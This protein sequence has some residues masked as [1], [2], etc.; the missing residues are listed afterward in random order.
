MPSMDERRI[1]YKKR[2]IRYSGKYKGRSGNRDKEKECISEGQGVQKKQYRQ[3]EQD[4]QRGQA[5]NPA[6]DASRHHGGQDGFSPDNDRVPEKKGK[7]E[8]NGAPAFVKKTV[9]TVKRTAERA[10]G[11]THAETGN[12]ME[13]DDVFEE[14]K[15]V[16]KTVSVAGGFFV[17]TAAAVKGII[18]LAVSVIKL[19]FSNI[20][21]LGTVLAVTLVGSAI[22][23]ISTLT[24]DFLID[25]EENVASYI[26]MIQYNFT[27]T[28]KEKKA[29]LSCDG[30]TVSGELTDWKEIISFW[31]AFRSRSSKSDRQEYYLTGVDIDDLTK[32][33]YEFN[34]VTY[35]AEPEGEKTMLHVNIENVTLGYMMD[36]YA[37]TTEQRTYVDELLADKEL[38]KKIFSTDELARHAVLETG[39]T[40]EK[41]LEWYGAAENDNWNMAYVMYLIDKCGAGQTVT[42]TLSAEA[43]YN[44][45]QRKGYMSVINIPSEGDIMFLSLSGEMKCG[46][47]TN[48][49][50]V[51]YYVTTG[52]YPGYDM[53]TEIVLDKKSGLII[54]CAR[55][56]VS[57]YSLVQ[58]DIVIAGKFAWPV[59]GYYYVTSAYGARSLLGMSFHYGMDIG[60]PTGTPILACLDGTV[61]YAGYGY[62]LGN[63][64]TID[65]GEG[66]KTVYGHNSSLAVK[67]G[68]IVTQGQVI[69]Y[70]GS[71]GQSTGPHCH[72]GVML[73]GNYNDP[74]QYFGLP[75]GFT[76]DAAP[77]IQ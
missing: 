54:G 48:I 10:G 22:M 51:A 11:K 52:G 3:R 28:M 56:D 61:T 39:Q 64:I 4:G 63:Y 8:E 55:I 66:L 16:K 7:R 25:E 58:P 59:D 36:D 60:C 13:D 26:S 34:S 24:Y 14:T 32:I 76:G 75:V 57:I 18:T 40:K 33:F 17:G 1:R 72:I 5:G 30:I 67:R 15:S 37:F 47:I 9:R 77:Y 69:A 19:L 73:S 70:A 42:K 20:L 12:A 46:I 21:I 2:D 35:A 62:S 27:G 68:D 49:D 41:Y 29:E 31:W 38:W 50:D 43:F 23:F 53:V 71:T 6:G 74:S 44:E 65:H 45:M